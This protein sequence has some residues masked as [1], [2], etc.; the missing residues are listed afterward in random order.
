MKTVLIL[1]LVVTKPLP[2]TAQERFLLT[3]KNGIQPLW[4][5]RQQLLKQ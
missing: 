5:K 4:R 3:S 1:Y 2:E